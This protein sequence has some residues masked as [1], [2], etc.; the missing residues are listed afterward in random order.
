MQL[1][2]TTMD[3]LWTFEN[4]AEGEELLLSV[5]AVTA[6]NQKSPRAYGYKTSLT[7][8]SEPCY[9]A[10]LVEWG[11][12]STEEL[13]EAVRVS[14]EVG[15]EQRTQRFELERGLLQGSDGAWTFVDSVKARGTSSSN[16]NYHLEEPNAARYGATY[17]RIRMVDEDGLDTLSQEIMH[18]RVLTSSSNE[19]SQ[20]TVSSIMRQQIS[21]CC[22]TL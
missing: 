22:K 10:P 13:G 5:N 19:E 20:S 3:T 12:L 14:W 16:I 8:T 4:L 17:Y 11:E 6:T 1:V 18:D 21:L 7:S 9:I 2:G 15:L